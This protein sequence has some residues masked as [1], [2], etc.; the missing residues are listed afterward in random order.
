MRKYSGIFE[1]VASFVLAFVIIVAFFREKQNFENLALGATTKTFFAEINGAP[2]QTLG[3]RKQAELLKGLKERNPEKVVLM[4]GNS[5]SHSINQLK[6]GDMTFTALLSDSLRPSSTD[7]LCSSIPNATLEDYYLLYKGWKSRLKIDVLVLPVFLDDTREEGIQETFYHDLGDFRIADKNEVAEKV[8]VQLD[9]MNQQASDFPALKQTF[10]EKT[11]NRIN[12]ILDNHFTP[13]H[14][15]ANVRGV[16]FNDLNK[17]RNTVFGINASTKRPVIRNT[18]ER[19]RMALKAILDD[20]KN[21]S[22]PVLL[23]IPPI[24]NDYE[25]PYISSEYEAFKKE[26][27]ALCQ[28]YGVKFMNLENAVPNQYWGLKGNRTLGGGRYDIDF[29]HFQ[30]PGHKLVAAALQPEIKKLLTNR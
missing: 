27:E 1:L 17:L 21:S 2:I 10:Q 12:D 4:L 30:Y 24:R 8:N 25:I 19:N 16:V 14:L 26:M 15:R 18:Y 20:C 9:K 23:Y 7:V 3:F 6:K 5:Q 29:M 11:E 13:W 22:I 28:Q